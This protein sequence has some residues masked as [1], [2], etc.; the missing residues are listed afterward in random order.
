ML[1]RLFF[2]VIKKTGFK[3]A[4]AE[5]NK[6]VPKPEKLNALNEDSTFAVSLTLIDTMLF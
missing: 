2:E 1:G 3:T 6:R 4:K 5:P